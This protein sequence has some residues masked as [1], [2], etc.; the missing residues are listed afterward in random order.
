M[1]VFLMSIFWDPW[2]TQNI[3]LPTVNQLANH[4]LRQNHVTLFTKL[5]CRYQV[6]QDPIFRGSSITIKRRRLQLE[7]GVN[8]ESLPLLLNFIIFYYNKN[9]ALIMKVFRH[10]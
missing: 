4:T 5:L 10:N 1:I 9:A 6:L 2:G 3:R 7:V 8:D